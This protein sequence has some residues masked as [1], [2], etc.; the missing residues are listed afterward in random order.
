MSNAANFW[1]AKCQEVKS[2]GHSPRRTSAPTKFTGSPKT[3]K[4]NGMLSNGAS[5]VHRSRPASNPFSGTVNGIKKT[6][7][8]DTDRED[9]FLPLLPPSGHVRSLD[10]QILEKTVV[11][12]DARITELVKSLEQ[13]NVR[14]T[15]LEST[16]ESQKGFITVVQKITEVAAEREEQL[17]K[18]NHKQ[19]LHVQK[20]V[21]EVDEKDRK[22][23]ALEDE[24]E[25]RC[26]TIANTSTQVS[27]HGDSGNDQDQDIILAIPEETDDSKSVSRD[28][29]DEPAMQQAQDTI[30]GVSGVEKPPA[31]P[32]NAESA[33]VTEPVA[34]TAPK[35][36]TPPAESAGPAVNDSEFPLFAT[37]ATVKQVPAPPPAPKLK[38]AVD[39]SKFAKKPASKVNSPKKQTSAV[40]NSPIASTGNGPA[41]RI[42]ISA[43][44]RKKLHD[45]RK[46]FGNG[47]KVQVKMGN[48]VLATLP[49]YV[50]MQCSEKAFRYFAGNPNTSSFDVPANSMDATA[51]VVHLEWMQDMTSQGRVYS[52]SLH[53]NESFDD[54]NLQICR[55]SR[56]LGLNNMYI[57]HFTRTFCDRIRSGNSSYV[58]MS[59]IAA[60]AYPEN[61]PIYDC[62]TNNLATQRMHGTCK[63]PAELEALL[64][65]YP[66][67]KKDVEK[68]E[69]RIRS[70]QQGHAK[71]AEIEK[72]KLEKK[73]K[74]GDKAGHAEKIQNGE[75]GQNGKKTNDAKKSANG[76]KSQKGQ[77][78]QKDMK[79]PETDKNGKTAQGGKKMDM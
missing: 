56:V 70:K 34:P 73:V 17:R 19:F 79:G 18:E 58:F 40:V 55:A 64:E 67:L 65:K 2:P 31:T 45:E 27:M 49:K 69:A 11:A 37:A 47:P 52:I 33:K 75:K 44:I 66:G 22:I 63:K 4:Q 30:K 59:K 28:N 51:A 53:P 5:P 21:S 20:L 35:V 48:A 39:V 7:R 12:K 6:D 60:L 76:Q 54:K 29:D 36:S 23:A 3:P 62:L 14:I 10:V 42:D 26:A 68:D 72:G 61:D 24:I 38:M 13:K 46:L 25:E 57:G 78:R 71:M 50:L 43:D 8:A 74:Q 41:P 16:L 32:V 1:A 77:N 15:E 9:Q